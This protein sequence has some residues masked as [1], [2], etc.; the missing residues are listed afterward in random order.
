MGH[1]WGVSDQHFEHTKCNNFDSKSAGSS[2]GLSEYVPCFLSLTAWWSNPLFFWAAPQ[3]SCFHVLLIGLHHDL[4][5]FFSSSFKPFT[6]F[7][8]SLQR[9]SQEKLTIKWPFHHWTYSIHCRIVEKKA[10]HKMWKNV[11][12]LLPKIEY[13]DIIEPYWI[14][15]LIKH[16]GHQKI[17]E[18]WY[19]Y[20]VWASGTFFFFNLRVPYA[21][22]DTRVPHEGLPNVIL[23]SI[24]PLSASTLSAGTQVLA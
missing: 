20:P 2:H 12:C 3:T 22:T 17:S 1:L 11:W 13:A 14:Y 23:S 15:N 8:V 4:L 5:R 18:N 6:S 10:D 21:S 7:Q 24:W 9:N 16:K 19:M